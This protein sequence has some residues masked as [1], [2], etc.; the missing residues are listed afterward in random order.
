MTAATGSGAAPTA[1]APDTAWYALSPEEAATQLGVDPAV[2]LASAEI[3]T[4]RAKYGKNTFA[5]AKKAS[6]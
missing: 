5:E 6:R 2:G 1:A 4:R 3:E